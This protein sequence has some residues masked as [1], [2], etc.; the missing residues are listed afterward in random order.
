MVLAEGLIQA[1]ET[2]NASVVAS[3]SSA[4]IMNAR[5]FMPPPF[6]VDACGPTSPATVRLHL[7]RCGSSHA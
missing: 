3:T 7:H 1:I 6:A 2:P 4:A 5:P